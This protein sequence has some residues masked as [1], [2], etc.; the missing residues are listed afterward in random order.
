[1]KR[2]EFLARGATAAAGLTLLP[3]VAHAARLPLDDPEYRELAM[4]AVDAAKRAGASYADVRINR[5]RN[6][7]IGTRE[8]RIT[9]FQDSETFGF[10]VR[11]LAGGSVLVRQRAGGSFMPGAGQQPNGVRAPRLCP[12]ARPACVGGRK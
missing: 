11:V 9:G 2:R 1:M 6:Q 3:G 8:R 4:R 5:N 10:G 7:S 12:T